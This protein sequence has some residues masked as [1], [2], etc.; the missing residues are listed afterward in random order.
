M[1]GTIASAGSWTN[2]VPPDC[3]TVRAPS[4]PSPSAPDSTTAT[5]RPSSAAAIDRSM[6]STAGRTPFSFGPRVSSMRPSRTSRCRS[7]G[8]TYTCAA[9]SR[10]PCSAATTC[11][12]QRR[13]RICG[14]RLRPVGAMCS[15]TQMGY[16]SAAGR[17]DNTLINASIPPADAPMPMMRGGEPPAAVT[18]G[19]PTP[20]ADRSC[21]D[22]V[23]PA[24]G[25]R[26]H[27]RLRLIARL[28]LVRA[29]GQARDLRAQVGEH[30]LL[31]GAV[32]GRE[33]RGDAVA[34]RLGDDLER[35]VR[36]DL[37]RLG[38]AFV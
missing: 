35:V 36:R 16:G 25:G 3:A 33:P 1:L 6:V 10:A 4:L 26:F 9:R 5:A 14:S 38:R 21:G 18:Q 37:E 34:R 22:F 32:L 12:A 20:P 8:A 11:R 27:L 30:A 15:T 23:G 28:L 7:G 31:L 13:S 29:D 24:R 17:P 2:T 19:E